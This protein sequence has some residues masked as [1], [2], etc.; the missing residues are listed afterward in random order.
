MAEDKKPIVNEKK[1]GCTSCSSRDKLIDSL[2]E[3]LKIQ[4]EANLKLDI[5]L[6]TV[7][8]RMGLK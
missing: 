4:E 5:L 3:R 2:E 6:Q 7:A 8:G 1:T